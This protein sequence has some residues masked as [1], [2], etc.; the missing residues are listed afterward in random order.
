MHLEI[1]RQH[2]ESTELEMHMIM[3]KTVN[4]ASM[5]GPYDRVITEKEGRNYRKKPA[6]KDSSR[7]SRA[8]PSGSGS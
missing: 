8:A 7:F 5:Q 1:A 6:A 2:M 3:G 4:K